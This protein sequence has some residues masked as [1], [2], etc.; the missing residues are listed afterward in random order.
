MGWILC[1]ESQHILLGHSGDLY[2]AIAS[3]VQAGWQHAP[4]EWRNLSAETAA[5]FSSLRAI[6]AEVN[7]VGVVILLPSPRMM[8]PCAAAGTAL[9]KLAS[10][11]GS[12]VDC[13][14]MLRHSR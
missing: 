5:T 9:P 7:Q 1:A 13:T 12:A 14:P 10:F 3:D 11:T 4:D 6:R 8:R 2:Q